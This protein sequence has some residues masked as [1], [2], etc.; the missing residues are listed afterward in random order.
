MDQADG[1]SLGSGLDPKAQIN[2]LVS[3]A[4]LDRVTG[5][6]ERAKKAGAKLVAGERGVPE[7][8]YFVAP[9]ILAGLKPQD[10][11]VRDEIRRL[12]G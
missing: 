1:M 6:V 5:F 8:G 3:K 7:G 12:S 2:P 4:Q 11:A 9:T 10:E